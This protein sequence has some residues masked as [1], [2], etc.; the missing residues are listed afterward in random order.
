M[1]VICKRGTSPDINTY[2]YAEQIIDPVISTIPI[3]LEVGRNIMDDNEPLIPVTLTSVY[4]PT[5]TG[6]L[7][8][9]SDELQADVWLGECTGV[10]LRLGQDGRF[11]VTQ[12]L[13][14][15]VL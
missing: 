9:V 10:E 1:R 6:D 12:Q 2:R 5:K 14:R 11:T 3:A 13:L 15:R 4:V 8:G 7:I